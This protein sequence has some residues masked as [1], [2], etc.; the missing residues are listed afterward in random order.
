MKTTKAWFG[1]FFGILAGFSHAIVNVQQPTWK[2]YLAA[3]CAGVISWVG[4]YSAPKNVEVKTKQ[5]KTLYS[6]KGQVSILEVL[7][8][9][10]L[11][12]GI[13][14]LILELKS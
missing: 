10:L 13:V 1:A 6:D 14:W 5:I 7:V 3:L 2:D 11:I 12:L 4:V 9:I 8:V